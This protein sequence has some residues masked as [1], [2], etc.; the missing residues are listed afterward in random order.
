M[1]VTAPSAGFS[2]VKGPIAQ[3]CVTIRIFFFYC[4]FSNFIQHSV[5]GNQ[6][7]MAKVDTSVCF[8]LLT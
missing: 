1:K 3:T 2:L 4:M 7:E 8:A 6:S 5:E